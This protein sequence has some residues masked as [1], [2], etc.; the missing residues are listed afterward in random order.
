M[1]ADDLL[2]Y[3]VREIFCWMGFINK[4]KFVIFNKIFYN[5]K[6]IIITSIING[7]LRFK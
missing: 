4:N 3:D 1:V 6:D 2:N 5:D 7:V